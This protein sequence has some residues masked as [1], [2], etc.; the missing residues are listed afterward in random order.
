MA[1]VLLGVSGGI[2]A[3]KA[4]ELIRLATAAGHA[5]R[6]VQ[7]PTSRRFVGEAS[8]AALSGAPVL[9]DEFE[10]DPAR[11]AFPDQAPPAHDPLSH[12]EL[13]RNADAYLIAPAS[14]NTIAKLAGGLADNL[15]TSAALAA[16]CPLVV[17]PAMNDAM[18]EHAA[19]AANVATLRER[20]VTVLEP[21]V[22]RLASKGETG[23]GR[24]PEP[25]ELLAAVESVLV[26]ERS[27]GGRAG[28]KGLR[29][30]VSA[31]GTREPIDAVRFVGNRSSGRMG[32]A[33][34]DAAARRGAQ[35]TVVAANVG[36]PA[37][38]GVE[39]V[40]VETAAQLQAA[41]DA[42]FDACD[43]LLMAAAVADF[44][45][46]EAAA[47]KLKKDDM[48][49]ALTITMQR[50]PDVLTGLAARRRPGQTLV[51]FAAETGEHAVD[52]GR[53]KL[54]AKGLDAVVVNDVGKPGAGFDV[55]TNEVT[56]VTTSG[57]RHVALAS[58]GEI[59]EAVLDTVDAVR[60]AAPAP[61]SA[62]VG[63]GA[64]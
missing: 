7:T 3:Y 43:V 15:L 9:T 6:V 21:G 45:P 61:A 24:L 54:T 46:A 2:A 55:P 18:W 44:R 32:F 64:R 35:V 34:A 11:G 62:A 17:A 50:T 5:V 29:V 56:I 51:G 63:G 8:F 1:R 42:H 57:E 33:L 14:A 12:L 41:C 47:H 31:G 58:K 59:A 20:G 4:L 36:L 53:R 22:G 13:V 16:R 25:A 26:G 23:A 27:A 38:S 48:G 60:A 39:V 28:W 19:T 10:R 49:D 30:L 40:A 52:Y 37:G